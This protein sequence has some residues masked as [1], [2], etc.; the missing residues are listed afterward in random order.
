MVSVLPL[1]NLMTTLLLQVNVRSVLLLRLLL[2]TRFVLH[3]MGWDGP[4][5]SRECKGKGDG[6]KGQLKYGEDGQQKPTDTSG[7]LKTHKEK[8]KREPSVGANSTRKPSVDE[9]RRA[10]QS[11]VDSEVDSSP[12]RQPQK[13]VKVGVLWPAKFSGR[14]AFQKRPHRAAVINFN[15]SDSDSPV[16]PPPPPRHRTSRPSQ[17][18]PS[19]SRPSAATPQG[20]EDKFNDDGEGMDGEE[21]DHEEEAEDDDPTAND[22]DPML[23]DDDLDE[24]EV[25]AVILRGQR[26]L[27]KKQQDK[28]R[29]EMPEIRPAQVTP[30]AKKQAKTHHS[31]LV[32]VS[33][34]MHD[35]IKWLPRTR[36]KIVQNP[37]SVKMVKKAQNANV[38][39]VMSHA[40]V[41]GDRMMV[42]GRE[43]DRGLNV[44][45]DAL[46]TMLTPMDKA[47]I[48]RI[49][50][51]ALIQSADVL[52][53]PARGTL[54]TAWNAG[55]TSTISN[56]SRV[57]SLIFKLTVPAEDAGTVPDKTLLLKEMNYIYPWT[58]A[59][60]FDRRAPY[61]SLVIKSAVRLGFFTNVVYVG[62]GLQNIALCT[63]SLENKPSEFEVPLEMVALAMTAVEAVIHEHSLRISKPIEFGAANAPAYHEHRI[64]LADFRQQKPKRY[65]RVMHDI[66]KAVTAGHT[67]HSGTHG[68]GINWDDVPDD[69]E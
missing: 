49:G 41:L 12:E 30:Q 33:N 46:N 47:G 16:P 6:S 1:R 19:Q 18:T 69:D 37:K 39:Q 5:G 24:E 4:K 62:I 48:D 60:G 63:S 29:S 20:I 14:Q 2:R 67:L 11:R 57:M 7:Q 50:L 43:E 15:D 68:T 28:L 34:K 58:S 65:H 32:S 8:R 44:T 52:G 66:F 45:S 56:R 26:Q 17:A 10:P 51:E 38:Q 55:R 9:G 59:G 23:G 25:P 53:T 31:G 35:G 54:L 64:R 3:S 61:E 21:A 42:F 36:I 13:K 40:Y 22:S 27:T